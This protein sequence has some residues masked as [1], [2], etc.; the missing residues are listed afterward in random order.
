MIN[1]GNLRFVLLLVKRKKNT[2]DNILLYIL[3][4]CI[5]KVDKW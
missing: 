2:A 1:L 3:C 5:Q 4:V